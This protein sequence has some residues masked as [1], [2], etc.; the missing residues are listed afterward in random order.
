MK[1]IL[2]V[3]LFAISLSACSRRDSRV[4]A[5]NADE[6]LDRSSINEDEKHRLYTAALAVSESPLDTELFSKVC[7]KIGI[8]DVNGKSTDKYM[9][10]VQAHVDWV[11][12][13][14]NEQF[15]AE[16]NSKEKA[17]HYLTVHLA[18]E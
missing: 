8:Y 14:E 13:P 10:F 4:S 11:T 12:K 6:T 9:S 18:A 5:A 1:V 3:V 16:I 2:A 7:K 15:R 17:R